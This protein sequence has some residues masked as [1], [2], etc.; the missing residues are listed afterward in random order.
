MN[1][2]IRTLIVED[3]MIIAL[4]L[5]MTMTR[6]SFKVLDT[7]RTGKDAIEC[8]ITMKPDLIMMDI[9]LADN[10]SGIE[11]ANAILAHN[12]CR[13]IFVTANSDSET[14]LLAMGCNPFAYYDKPINEKMVGE[15][16]RKMTR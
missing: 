13:I 9:R 6:H 2:P 8:A 11:A 15:I 4:E 14:K 16:Y 3:E 12:D 5:K 10:I 7:V 1:L